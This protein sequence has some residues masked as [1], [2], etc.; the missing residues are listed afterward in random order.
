MC[1]AKP[2]LGKFLWLEA[3]LGILNSL[4]V[5]KCRIRH[6]NATQIDIGNRI[7][8]AFAGGSSHPVHGRRLEFSRRTQ[9]AHSQHPHA[10]RRLM[11]SHRSIWEA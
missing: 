10:P 11:E 5:G 8:F 3:Q 9:M 4:F 1:F 6:K 7:G 2:A